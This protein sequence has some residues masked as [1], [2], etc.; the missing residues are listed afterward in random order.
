[1]VLVAGVPLFVG[2][3]QTDQ[4]FAWT[5]RPPLTAAVLG[6]LYWSA[7]PFVFLSAR[8]REW[9]NARLAVPGVLVFTTL[10]LIATVLHAD[11]FHFTSPVFV[12]RAVAW[13]WLAIYVLVP[14]I[15]AI[16]LVN[17]LRRARGDPA[18]SQPLPA[19]CLRYI[20]SSGA[21]L[22]LQTREQLER[23][24]AAPV[25]ESYGM[26]E[27]GLI[28]SNPMPP[29]ER[30]PGSVGRAIGAEIAVIDEAGNR[31]PPGTDGEVIVRGPSVSMR[32]RCASCSRSPP[33]NTAAPT[34]A[35]HCAM[36]PPL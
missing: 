12:A 14:P 10:G 18:R 15:T 1:M 25:I 32:R 23:L 17:Q 30:P 2:S 22:S 21:P 6:A 35:R 8:E 20:P 27:A 7:V 29:G 9:A 34:M 16:L 13:A 31:L 3:E 26:T 24:F 4:Y 5:I 28:T 11:R 36:R 19:P 33:S